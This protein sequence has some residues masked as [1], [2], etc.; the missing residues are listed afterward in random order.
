MGGVR[1]ILD[2]AG[3][4]ASC[5]DNKLHVAYG[6]IPEGRFHLDQKTG[7]IFQSNSYAAL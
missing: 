4:N 5:S 2:I 1:V 3:A 6:V 7:E